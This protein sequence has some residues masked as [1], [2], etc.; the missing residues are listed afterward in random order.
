MIVEYGNKW[1]W[2][3]ILC[4]DKKKSF[5]YKIKIFYLNICLL[6]YFIS[7]LLVF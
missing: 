7:C 1:N 4:F 6:N 2:N 5:I 3:Y